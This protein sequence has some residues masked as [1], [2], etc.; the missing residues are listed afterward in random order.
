MK[1]YRRCQNAECMLVDEEWIIVHADA[2]TITKLNE[3]GGICWD[4]LGEK[5]TSAA[6]ARELQLRFEIAEERA[7]HDVELFLN[8]LMKL[9]LVEEAS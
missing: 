6:L 3:V 7:S 4:M 8:E 9:K 1:Q 2:S 5:Q